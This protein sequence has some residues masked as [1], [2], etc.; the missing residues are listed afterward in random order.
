[1]TRGRKSESD[2]N[3]SN[4]SSGGGG[5]GGNRV[6]I[7]GSKMVD[8]L[9]NA[10]MLNAEDQRSK[11]KL[12]GSMNERSRS[13]NVEERQPKIKLNGSLNESSGFGRLM[14]KNSL[15]MALKHMVLLSSFLSFAF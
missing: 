9:M 14:S 11:I 3:A 10:R 8:R 5:G 13:C 6:Q 2:G 7:V 1:M 12:N 4:Q 15:D